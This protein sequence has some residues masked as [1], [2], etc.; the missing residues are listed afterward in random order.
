MEHFL[1]V[2]QFTFKN[3]L[4]TMSNWTKDFRIQITFSLEFH[5][6]KY[7][8]SFNTTQ[9]H[10]F[11][12]IIFRKKIQ[13]L[14]SINWHLHRTLLFKVEKHVGITQPPVFS[15]RF[16]ISNW[17]LV[18][19]L[20]H[21]NIYFPQHYTNSIFYLFKFHKQN[22]HS[23]TSNFWHVTI[24]LEVQKNNARVGSRLS[25][26][27]SLLSPPILVHCSSPSEKYCTCWPPFITTQ[28]YKAIE[29]G[30]TSSGPSPAEG[31]CT[32]TY[33]SQGNPFTLARI[34]RVF[35]NCFSNLFN[36]LICFQRRRNLFIYFFFLIYLFISW[37]L[38]RP[39]VT[40]PDCGSITP[41]CVTVSNFN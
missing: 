31:P 34:A 2:S 26:S 21:V 22:S 23:V 19:I 40:A 4:S 8:L 10:F 41:D 14:Y 27:C 1:W 16:L 35:S 38:V 30:W 28:W 33:R 32:T 9:I 13:W 37:L 24:P 5:F 20:F 25:F 6:K 7:V 12:W 15:I 17:D 18:P 29:A 3:S 11:T 39:A 36:D